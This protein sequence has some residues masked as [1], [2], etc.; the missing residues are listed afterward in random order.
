MGRTLR[1]Y[2]TRLNVQQ[3]RISKRLRD[4]GVKKSIV[5]RMFALA[6]RHSAPASNMPS[7]NTDAVILLSVLLG[8]DCDLQAI[9]NKLRGNTEN[10]ESFKNTINNTDIIKNEISKLS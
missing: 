4:L 7:A 6:H 3:G 10:G 2:R 9:E 1:T 8:A 5:D